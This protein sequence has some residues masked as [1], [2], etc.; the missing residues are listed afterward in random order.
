MKERLQK[1]IAASHGVSRR[2]AEE[3]IKAGKVKINGR[4]ATIGE[5][6]DPDH[7]KIEVEGRRLANRPKKTYIALYKPRGYVTTMSDEL[8][9]HTVSELVQDLNARL[10]PVGRLDMDSE[11]LLLMTND[12]EWANIVA[13]PSNRVEKTYLVTVEGDPKAASITMSKGMDIVDENGEVEYHV[14]PVRVISRDIQENGGKLVITICEGHN[15]EVRRM[16]E[17]CGLKVKRLVRIAIGDIPVQG[18]KPGTWR[19]LE[20]EE[21][22]GLRGKRRKETR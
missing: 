19:M 13:H 9:R 11:G 14:D 15:R 2:G 18:I 16:C 6:A 7:D 17:A 8:G 10:F 5:S 3:L 21:I 4:V 12:G 22:K 1:V 20:E